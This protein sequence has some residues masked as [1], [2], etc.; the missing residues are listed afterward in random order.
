MFRILFLLWIFSS[1]GSSPAS[2]QVLPAKV[3]S[4]EQ[5]TLDLKGEYAG[6]FGNRYVR[7]L[8]KEGSFSEFTELHSEPGCDSP[9][10]PTYERVSTITEYG[11]GF[12]KIESNGFFNVSGP[13]D[14]VKFSYSENL[15]A[16]SPWPQ[17]VYGCNE[18]GQ[19][20]VTSS[21]RF[22]VNRLDDESI[23]FNEGVFHRVTSR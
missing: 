13:E 6:C 3:E 12:W 18:S 16:W 4:K 17:V 7:Y 9:Q 5:V 23:E 19:N 1:C 11:D 10:S 22:R 2:R 8:F 20:G 14:F 21:G 15:C